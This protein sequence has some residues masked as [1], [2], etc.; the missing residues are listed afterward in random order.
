M[1]RK[2]KK[3]KAK[4]TWFLPKPSSELNIEGHKG[5]MPYG[6]KTPK[7]YRGC[8]IA[9]YFVPRTPGGMLAE[10]TRQAEM[11]VSGLFRRQIKIV[12]KPGTKLQE[13]LTS[14]NPWAG[15]KCH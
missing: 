6:D 2:L 13:M 1:A 10:M 9:V 15:E 14:S 11:I 3:L 4:Q 5:R 12:E 7:N 8:A